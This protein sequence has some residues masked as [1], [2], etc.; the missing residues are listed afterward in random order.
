[1]TLSDRAVASFLGLALG[2]ATGRPLE[3]TAGAAVRTQA[4]GP[5]HDF[6]WTD[7]THMALYVAEAALAHGPGPL[8]AD[9][10]GACVGE[11]FGR[12][13]DDPLTPSTAPGN[14]CLAGARAWV[15][16]RDWRASGVVRSDGC[17]A[18]MRVV[19]LPI[20]FAGHDLA[21]AAEV[22]ARLT[23]GHAN[24][25]HAA[26]AACW[27][28]RELLAGRSLGP[29]LVDEA[30]AALC[31]RHPEAARGATVRA[32]ET[33]VRLGRVGAE[34]LEEDAVGDGDG[35]WRSPSALGLAV[36]A[37]LR[38]G[39][40]ADG[41]VTAASFALAVEKAARIFGDSDSV[42]CLAGMLLG[43]A[44]GTGVLPAA[45]LAALPEAERIAQTARRLAAVAPPELPWVAVADLHGHVDHLDALVGHLDARYGDAYRLALLGDYLDNGPAIPA[46]LDRL[47]ALRAERP[48]RFV[49]VLGN[50]DLACLRALGW[51][52][53]APDDA[54]YRR[55]AGRYWN[56][57]LGTGTAYG[58][59][60][61][62]SLAARM[63]ARHQAFL[64][65][66]PWC[67]DTGTYLFVHAGMEAGPLGPQREAL[68]AR[69]LPA[70]HLHLPPQLREKALA[71]VSDPVWDRVVV[72]GHT[73][74]PASRSGVGRSAPHVMT[75]RR[76]CLSGEV[77]ATGRLFAVELPSRRVFEV[78]EALTVTGH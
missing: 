63:P 78:S 43:A 56:S 42:A 38:W 24:A 77:D 53:G 3:F 19:A 75:P 36:L 22:Q 9:R 10:F 52:G 34:W 74:N 18:V 50:H 30:V 72:S 1:M 64:A 57:G 67:Y 76:I 55:W 60:D 44:G 7:D 29:W 65:S 25:T 8:D 48:G 31:R 16:G 12:W 28:M 46:L 71:G 66:L 70:G 11:Q 5:G 41:R 15:R 23:H 39:R 14:T 59:R 54:W 33:A 27:L 58:A 45:W 17:G 37:A 73:K 49:A 62:S 20:V 68:A 13:L 69:R 4:A 21:L 51:P 26:V 47:I 61:A 35:G 40:E 6:M 2:D 32:L